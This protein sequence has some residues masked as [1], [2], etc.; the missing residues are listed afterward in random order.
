MSFEFF[1]KKMGILCV[2]ACFDFVC[3]LKTWNML[4]ALTFKAS[5]HCLLSCLNSFFAEKH[6]LFN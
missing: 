5:F 2:F 6:A 3:S 4:F 1:L